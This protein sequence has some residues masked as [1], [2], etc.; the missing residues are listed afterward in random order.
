MDFYQAIIDRPISEP[1]PQ[2]Q[3]QP[4]PE[5]QPQDT[6]PNAFDVTNL[7]NQAR[8]AALTTN[9]VTVTG[10]DTSVNASTNVGTIVK[11]GVDT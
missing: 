4:E 2:P 10:I 5:P 1:E 3:P 8:N 6:T 11:N 7:T 9:A